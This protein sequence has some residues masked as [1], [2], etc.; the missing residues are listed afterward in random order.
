MPLES[1]ALAAARPQ[2]LSQEPL[3][4][5]PTTSQPTRTLRRPPAADTRRSDRRRINRHG[6][7]SRSLDRCWHPHRPRPDPPDAADAV[8]GKASTHK[9][10]DRPLLQICEIHGVGEPEFCNAFARQLAAAFVAGE[11]DA[12]RAEFAADDLHEA[13]DYALN[14]LALRVFD[15]LE[16]RESSPTEIRDLLDREAA[17][18]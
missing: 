14:G 9:K 6:R 13:A 7:E 16:Y 4:G 15:A 12:E 3:Q 17:S 8:K 18:L 1:D 11:I 2:P 10:S 5:R